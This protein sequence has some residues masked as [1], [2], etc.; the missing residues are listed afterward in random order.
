VPEDI[1]TVPFQR[2]LEQLA[3]SLRIEKALSP[4]LK[5]LDLRKE[6][7]LK[8]SHFLHR[9]K[10]LNLNWGTEEEISDKVR[11]SFNEKWMIEWQPEF[12]L[13]VIELATWGNTVLEATVQYVQHQL[14]QEEQL[15][16]LVEWLHDILNANLPE[17]TDDLLSVIQTRAT[18]THDTVLLMHSL[19]SLIHILR[20]GNVRKTSTDIV[21]AVV[22]SLVPRIAI[23]LPDLCTNIQDDD[24]RELFSL[25]THNQQ[26]ISLLNEPDLMDFWRDALQKL[27]TNPTTNPLLSGAA[28][29][30]LYNA[31]VFDAPTTSQQMS[32][33]LSKGQ[34]PADS[35]IWIEGFLHGS[36]LVLIHHHELWQLLHEWLTDLSEESFIENLP[37]LRRAFSQFSASERT[38]MLG[39]VKNENQA[40][41]A[42]KELKTI[43]NMEAVEKITQS[44]HFFLG[45]G[46]NK[47][48][49]E[50]I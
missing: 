23:A 26:S 43:Y 46:L 42:K 34:K 36:G 3:K 21:K 2:D 5:A 45:R 28:C 29:R 13:T 44:V 40:F 47:T 11:G 32:F 14:A 17:L 27:T 24:A 20:Y 6:H 1:P 8:V 16:I 37:L 25:I 41:D 35:A 19:P 38:K 4:T 49:I 39:L 50:K 22:Y 12:A 30:W 33:F 9:L 18:L 15:K 48:V 7:D 10:L 31:G